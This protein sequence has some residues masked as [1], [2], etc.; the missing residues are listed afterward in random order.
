[1]CASATADWLEHMDV[2]GTLLAEPVRQKGGRFLP[3]NT[4]GI[5]INWDRDKVRAHQMN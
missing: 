2:V 4:P 1:M 5:G 3:G